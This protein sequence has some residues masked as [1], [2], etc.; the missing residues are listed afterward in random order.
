[1]HRLLLQPRRLLN[2]FRQSPHSRP[3]PSKR[4]WL[5]SPRWKR[6]T[7]HCRLPLILCALLQLSKRSSLPPVPATQGARRVLQPI[8]SLTFT[9]VEEAEITSPIRRLAVLEAVAEA[10]AATQ[11]QAT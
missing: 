8:L 9:L 2:R 6:R 10:A 4:C 11:R 3:A 5:A 1:M 7:A